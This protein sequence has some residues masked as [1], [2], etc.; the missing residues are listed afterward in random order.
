MKRIYCLAMLISLIG[1]RPAS[2]QVGGAGGA[3]PDA[4]SHRAA[5]DQR[6]NDRHA[7]PPAKHEARPR[8]SDKPGH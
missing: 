8:A 7:P 1:I 6:S 3:L 5:I 4:R 2:A